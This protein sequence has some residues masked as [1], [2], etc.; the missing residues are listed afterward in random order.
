MRAA[1]RQ[2]TRMLHN[3]KSLMEGIVNMQKDLKN[4]HQQGMGMVKDLQQ[5]TAHHRVLVASLIRDIKW[6]KQKQQDRLRLK[7]AN[8]LLHEKNTELKQKLLA[9]ETQAGDDKRVLQRQVYALQAQLHQAQSNNSELQ[10]EIGHAAGEDG[11]LQRVSKEL[12]RQRAENGTHERKISDLSEA[13]KLLTLKAA[14]GEKA[15]R[16]VKLLLRAT[17]F[18]KKQ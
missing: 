18:Y 1:V 12:E 15:A 14:Q 11:E 17:G 3:N 5:N 8:G 6:I 13:V 7:Q 4:T 9:A 16:Q 2:T 10:N